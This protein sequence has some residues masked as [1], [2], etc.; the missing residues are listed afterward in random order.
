MS[1]R[2]FDPGDPSTWAMT[3]TAEQIALVYQ[4]KVGGIKKACQQGSFRPAPFETHPYRWRKV[5]VLRH[6]EGAR[7]HAL[8]RVS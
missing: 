2:P 4:R 5:D 6:V 3:L 8:R 7:G 1:L